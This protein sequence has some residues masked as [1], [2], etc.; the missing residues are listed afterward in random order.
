[1]TASRVGLIACLAAFALLSVGAEGCET[2]SDFGGSSPPKKPNQNKAKPDYGY[3]SAA[4]KPSGGDASTSSGQAATSSS[5]CDPSY[6]GCVPE[7]PPDVDCPDVGGPIQVTG[8]DPHGLDA[9]SDGV[10]C[11]S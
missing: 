5:G 1:L 10:A 11:E 6:S 9:D 8:S 7:Y 3:G 4:N 2:E